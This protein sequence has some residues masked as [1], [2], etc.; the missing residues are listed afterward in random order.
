MRIEGKIKSWKDDRGFGFIQSSQG[1]PDLFVHINAL[2]RAF[3]EPQIGSLVTFEIED[4]DD[5]KK[6]A[7]KVRL[8]AGNIVGAKPR[9]GRAKPWDSTSLVVLGVF[10]TSF[11]LLT[12]FW[13]LSVYVGVV[14]AGMSLVCAAVYW[15]DKA[16]AEA[17]LWRTSE[18]T[19]IVLGVLCGWPGAMIAQHVFQ[20][21]T[22]KPTFRVMH[23]TSV[24]L[25]LTVFY[26]VC[27]PLL[28]FMLSSH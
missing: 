13:H 19:L 22:T 11:L 1:G 15:G 25:N 27:T 28:P 17:G 14:Y 2:P 20:H 10:T 24:V 3:G 18:E 21:K 7:I 12:V 16:S 6:R 9:N 5:G 4:T 23:W 8:L 26:V